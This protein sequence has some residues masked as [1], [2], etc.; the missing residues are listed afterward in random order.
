MTAAKVITEE[1]TAKKIEAETDRTQKQSSP[2]HP[3][4]FRGTNYGI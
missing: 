1:E 2:N 3:R 4:F